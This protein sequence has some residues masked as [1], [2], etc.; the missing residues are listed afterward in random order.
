MSE[1]SE[2]SSL[3]G[4]RFTLKHLAYS[5]RGV[6]AAVLLSLLAGVLYGVFGPVVTPL[7]MMMGAVTCMAMLAAMTSRVMPQKLSVHIQPDQTILTGFVGWFGRKREIRLPTRELQL[8]RTHSTLN[9]RDPFFTLT[10]AA[11]QHLPVRFPMVMF[12]EDDLIRMMTVLAEH[13]EQATARAGEGVSEVPAA[14]QQ[15][16]EQ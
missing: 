16:Q 7:T 8:S 14:L 6:A 4:V 11:P 12:S 13:Q 5:S 1:L 9:R 15:L 10:A 3:S 2:E